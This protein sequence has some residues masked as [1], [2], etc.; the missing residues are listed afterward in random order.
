MFCKYCGNE[1]D[2]D[3]TLCK[4]CGKR[5]IEEEIKSTGD[6][7]KITLIPC[8]SCG[9][10][11]SNEAELC[12]HCGYKTSKAKQKE[13]ELFKGLFS[14]FS[15]ILW[16]VGVFLIVSSIP[17][18]QSNEMGFFGGVMLFATGVGIDIG[19]FIRNQRNKNSK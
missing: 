5:N 17:I 1:L 15:A 14:V 13:E 16:I 4:K 10:S 19:L 2:E 6:D 3:N 7:G 18:T 12:P 11:I 9:N 8:P